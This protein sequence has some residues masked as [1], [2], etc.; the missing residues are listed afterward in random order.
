MAGATLER[1]LSIT[2]TARVRFDIAGSSDDAPIRRL[3]RETPMVGQV[4]I[5]L[6]REPNYFADAG[7][8][9]ESKQTIVAYDN[10]RL[11]CVGSC[12]IRRR[13][14]NGQSCRAGYLGSLRMDSQYAGRFDIL[15]RGYQFFHKLQ[16]E[17]PADFYFTTIAADNERARRFLERGAAGMPIYEFV[18]EFVT[19][20]IPTNGGQSNNQDRE[21]C[22]VSDAP[23]LDQLVAFLNGFNQQHQFA[24]CWAAEELRSLQGLGLQAS[25][26]CPIRKD[27]NWMACGAVW[28]Q[29]SF[30]Q[31]VIHGYAPWLKWSRPILNGFN[32][33][34]NRPRLP[35]TG[36]TL[37]NAFGSHLAFA[38]DRPTE[39]LELT[40]LLLRAA[41]ERGI[42][43]LTLGLAAND[44]R[45]IV[46]R[47]TFSGR[48]YRSRLYVVRWPGIG[49]TAA[50]LDG[51]PLAPEVALL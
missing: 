29:R 33:A 6:E 15:R 46:A 27:G 18:G 14:V 9:S 48:E 17:A 49:G 5:S 8:P 37:S 23:P 19:L 51:C 11:A 42:K 16:T 13:F 31:T 32:R 7:L 45:L 38:S 26:F 40:E 28:D 34:L 22:T 10:E 50:E 2:R 41:R 30:K 12:S 1:Q 20:L 21:E 4:S 3:L 25:D 36:A 44:T 35:V 39:F 47:K 24:P 43:F